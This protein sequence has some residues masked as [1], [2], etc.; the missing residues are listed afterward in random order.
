VLVK[1]DVSLVRFV[2]DIA[3]I[4]EGQLDNR[5]ESPRKVTRFV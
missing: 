2:V 1:I 5:S 3:T 4:A